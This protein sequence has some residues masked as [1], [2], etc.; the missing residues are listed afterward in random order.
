MPQGTNVLVIGGGGLGAALPWRPAQR[1]CRVVLS[2]PNPGGGATQAAAGML[3]PVTELHHGELGLLALT[4]ASARLYPE[5]VAELERCTGLDVGY[6]R[7]GTVQVAWDRA[8]L[9]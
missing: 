7:C 5:F 8:D 6:V 3:A 2:D 1:G 9:V 4:T